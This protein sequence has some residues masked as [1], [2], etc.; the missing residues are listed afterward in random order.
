M[1]YPNLLDSFKVR[2][3]LYQKKI[4]DL[5]EFCKDGNHFANI[6]GLQGYIDLILLDLAQDYVYYTRLVVSSSLPEQF[7]KKIWDFLKMLEGLRQTFNTYV[8]MYVKF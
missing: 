5:Q 1:T 8:N 2:F 6:R 4:N 3:D 7:K